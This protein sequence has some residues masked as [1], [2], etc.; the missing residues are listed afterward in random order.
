MFLCLIHSQYLALNYGH[1]FARRVQMHWT[2]GCWSCFGFIITFTIWKIN[3]HIFSCT[4]TRTCAWMRSWRRSYIPAL[5]VGVADP[6]LQLPTCLSLMWRTKE[7]LWKNCF[8]HSPHIYGGKIPCFTV[9]WRFSSSTLDKDSGCGQC[10]HI[11]Y[12]QGSI[13]Y[14]AKYKHH[15]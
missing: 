4:R 14:P 1:D 13:T 2:F 12:L 10:M 3:K 9:M 11:R 8:L 7:V 6:R 15:R 5:V